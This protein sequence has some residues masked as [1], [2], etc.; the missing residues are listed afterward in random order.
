M[1]INDIAT[2]LL[3]HFSPEERSIPDFSSFLGRNGAV[4][5]AMNGALQELYGKASPW[6]R[7]DER[8]V[9]LHAPARVSV[10]VTEGGRGM[11]IETGWASWMAGCSVVLDGSAMDNQFRGD[12]E[13]NVLKY[14]HA[15]ATGVTGATVY[16]DCVTL[17]A[18]VMEVIGPVR[19]DRVPL[20]PL[21]SGDAPVSAS[22]RGDDD[23]GFH[24]R[25][26]ASPPAARVADLCG[27]PLGYAVETWATA[28][29][30]SPRIRLRLKPA[31][32]AEQHLDYRA[33][34]VPP[35]VVTNLLSTTEVPVPHGFVES[36]FFPIARQRLS[37]SPFFRADAM[38]RQEIARAYQEA[39]SLLESLNP[40]KDSG[41]KLSTLY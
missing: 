6:V 21:V 41:A 29:M 4:M 25:S 34:L 23:Y 12:S 28:A 32:A 40:R 27:R 39:I 7:H 3:L 17:D 36:L 30:S 10:S 18:D 11:E 31:P 20:G 9:L 26:V 13:V 16:H 15:G 5:L 22:E 35:V 19:V 33:M 24:R 2:Q 14:P 1:T 37:G 38:A 8:G